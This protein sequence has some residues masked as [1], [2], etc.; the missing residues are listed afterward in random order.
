MDSREAP[1]VHHQATRRASHQRNARAPREQRPHPDRRQSPS[2]DRRQ[3]AARVVGDEYQ[4][5]QTLDALDFVDALVTERAS[6]PLGSDGIAAR[7]QAR[8]RT[9]HL[10]DSDIDIDGDKIR[11]YMLVATAHDGTMSCIGKY[12][13]TRVVC[14]NTSTPRSARSPFT[15]PSGTPATCNTRSRW[16]ARLRR[17]DQDVPELRGDGDAARKHRCPTRRLDP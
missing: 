16:P 7:R 12:V 10:R 8:L 14:M 4:C 2:C 17:G 1:T 9:V 5:I 6:R 13:T 3:H 15:S 11:T